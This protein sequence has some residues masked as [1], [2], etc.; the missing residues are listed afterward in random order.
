[1]SFFAKILFTLFFIHL[2]SRFFLLFVSSNLYFSLVIFFSASFLQ[3]DSTAA[4]FKDCYHRI[5]E[6]RI[7][8]GKEILKI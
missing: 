5:L 6:H 3:C 4:D 2:H 8:Q 1:M 7:L